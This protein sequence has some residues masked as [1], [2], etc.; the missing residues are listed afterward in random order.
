MTVIAYKAGRMACDA[1]CVDLNT[2][3]THSKATKIKRTKAGA[4][5][6]QS[7]AADARAFFAL[8]DN[9][10]TGDKIPSSED[11]GKTKCHGNFLVVF[12]NSEVW[13]IDIY[14]DHDME[15][16]YGSACQVT[17]MHSIAHAGC[18]GELAMAFMRAG[19]S[20]KE[21]VA[22]VCEINAYC[23]PPIYEEVLHPKAKA[24]PSPQDKASKPSR[25]KART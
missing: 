10:K 6:G 15:E 12:R 21:A 4:L 3:A 17:G 11:L 25:R 19:K 22:A 1:L 18:G 8:M 20:A 24:S 5:I 16:W 2:G 14:P 9:V 13:S 23:A 7:G